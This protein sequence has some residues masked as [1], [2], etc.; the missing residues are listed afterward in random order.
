MYLHVSSTYRYVKQHV[1]MEHLRL[2]GEMFIIS[3][4][5]LKRKLKIMWNLLTN[6]WGLTFWQYFIP[7]DFNEI[8]IRFLKDF[9]EFYSIYPPPSEKT[10]LM[11]GALDNVATIF[12]ILTSS[13]YR[14]QIA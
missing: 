3:P 13:L 8:L 2:F 11:D 7:S 9:S 5:I 12:Y 14:V 4:H 10:S 6:F 1:E